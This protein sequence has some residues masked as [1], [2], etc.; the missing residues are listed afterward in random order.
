MKETIATFEARTGLAYEPPQTMAVLGR[1]VRPR[2]ACPTLYRYPGPQGLAQMLQ[3]RLDGMA[4]ADRPYVWLSESASAG[5]AGSTR[6]F[7]VIAL[8]QPLR[9]QV[10]QDVDQWLGENR[11]PTPADAL[12]WLPPGA[13][14]SGLNLDRLAQPEQVIKR[15]RDYAGDRARVTDRLGAYL[16]ELGALQ[17]AGAA[18]PDKPWCTLPAATRRKLLASHAITG[19]F[20]R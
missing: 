1:L 19:R 14:K 18:P 9:W 4:P 3:G 7:G 11:A 15:C 17:R 16:E 8:L 10:V 12:V 5:N 20:T 6:L 2:Q 13:I